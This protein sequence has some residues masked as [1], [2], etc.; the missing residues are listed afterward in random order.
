MREEVKKT[1]ALYGIDVDE[2]FRKLENTK[3]SIL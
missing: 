2:V 1:Y 3:M